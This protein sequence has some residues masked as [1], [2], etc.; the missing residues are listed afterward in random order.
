MVLLVLMTLGPI[1]GLGPV[2]ELGP[3][4]GLEGLAACACECDEGSNGV[5]LAL[6]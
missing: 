6:N 1:L 2:L 4:V 3:A 5:A